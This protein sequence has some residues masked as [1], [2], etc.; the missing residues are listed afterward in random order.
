M[1]IF[2]WSSHQTHVQ[3]A[4]TETVSSSDSVRGEVP[5]PLPLPLK[6][7]CRGLWELEPDWK[8]DS[9][10]KAQTDRQRGQRRLT[11]NCQSWFPSSH[12]TST[13]FFMLRV[14]LLCPSCTYNGTSVVRTTH[15][16]PHNSGTL[17][18]ASC[19]PLG[20]HSHST[21]HTISHTPSNNEPQPNTSPPI[22]NAAHLLVNSSPFSPRPLHRQRHGVSCALAT[23]ELTRLNTSLAPTPNDSESRYIHSS[24]SPCIINPR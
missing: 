18:E 7:A 4:S 6:K 13:L 19:F 12:D 3:P 21:T 15:I 1:D 16:V 20:L 10:S 23:Q 11:A 2:P 9:V 14:Q 17:P 8:S 24:V 5:L 22:R